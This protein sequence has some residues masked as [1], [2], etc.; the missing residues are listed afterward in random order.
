VAMRD[1]TIDT[2][3]LSLAGASLAAWAILATAR[4]R[5]WDV[6]S[7]PHAAGPDE[8]AHRPAIEAIVPARNEAATIGTT[9]AS[10]LEQR[11]GGHFHVTVVDDQ[12]SDGTAALARHAAAGSNAEAS[13]D[14]I[15]ARP[16]QRPWTGK[17]NALA[18]GMAH[19]AARRGRPDYWLFTD[20]DITHHP[21][22]VAELAIRMQGADCD[23]VSLMVRLHCESR[24]ERLLV[25]AF[26]FFFRKLYPFAWSNDP[27]RRTAAAAG[28]C[29]LIRDRALERIGGLD[30]I[31]GELIDDCALAAAVKASGGRIDLSLSA[32]TISTRTYDALAPLWAMVKRTAFTQLQRSYSFTGLAVAIMLLL[33]LAPP[34]LAVAGI[35]RRNAPLAATAASAWAIMAALYVPTLRLYGRPARESLALPLAALLYTLMTVDSALAESRGTGGR[36]KG[37]T[38]GAGAAEGAPTT[39]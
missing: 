30:A 7:A 12:S 6:G 20:A 9:V 1:R 31:A 5:F 29:I 11:Y 21:G 3:A 25:P 17:L 4:G 32:R 26:V 18:T 36:W 8:A 13:L 22:N 34:V 23:L 35:L 27:R 33:Y 24:W 19:V 28:G 2:L 10:L 15:A 39:A 37:R 14:V 38:Y 16:L